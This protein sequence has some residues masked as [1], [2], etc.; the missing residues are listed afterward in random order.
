MRPPDGPTSCPDCKFLEVS[1]NRLC[2][3]M[4]ACAHLPKPG[5]GILLD[6][7]GSMATRQTRHD[8]DEL[9]YNQQRVSTVDSVISVCQQSTVSPVRR[10]S[11]HF[12]ASPRRRT[13]ADSRSNAVQSHRRRQLA[14]IAVR[15]TTGREHAR[16]AASVSGSVDGADRLSICARAPACVRGRADER[17][18]HCDD[19]NTAVLTARRRPLRVRAAAVH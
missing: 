7:V 2:H 18:R 13:F 3:V 4:A 11:G 8:G 16:T 19:D 10:V 1:S 6:A 15:H 14:A 12:S 9:S 5:S 17:A